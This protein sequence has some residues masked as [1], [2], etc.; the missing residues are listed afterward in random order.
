M[1]AVRR[2]P[3]PSA[4]GRARPDHRRVPG[5][6]GTAAGATRRATAAEAPGP[7][8]DGMAPGNR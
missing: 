7:A 4:A 5:S 2:R 3:P 1:T 8:L 6:A